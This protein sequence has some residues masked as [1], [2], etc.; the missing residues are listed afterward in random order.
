[1]CRSHNLHGRK[2]HHSKIRCLK[3]LENKH[4]IHENTFCARNG[5]WGADENMDGEEGRAARFLE[6]RVVRQ[7]ASCKAAVA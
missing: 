7:E 1:M 3:H 4:S 6:E 5:K 2:Y